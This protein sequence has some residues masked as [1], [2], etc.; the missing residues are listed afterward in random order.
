[1]PKL[2]V[3]AFPELEYAQRLVAR[4]MRRIRLKKNLTQEQVAE[5]SNTTPVWISVCEK[6]TR[7]L[8]VRSLS[9][10]AYGLGVPMAALLDTKDYPETDRTKRVYSKQAPKRV[11]KS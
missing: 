4:N 6:G 2:S 9:V 7:N 10:I 5:L 11:T 8:S 1:M 3:A